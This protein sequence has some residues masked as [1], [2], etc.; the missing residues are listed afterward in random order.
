MS[1][2]IT[3]LNNLDT[4]IEAVLEENKSYLIRIEALEK[5]NSE[6]KKLLINKKEELEKKELENTALRMNQN[7]EA[8][9]S[10]DIKTKINEMVR[11]I[12]KCIAYLN[13]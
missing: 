11:E 5:E 13:K 1:L 9:N 7:I 2:I 4:K 10:N 8:E 12:D 6:L 3:H